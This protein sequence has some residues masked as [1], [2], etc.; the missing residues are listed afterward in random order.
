[1]RGRLRS[2]VPGPSMIVALAA[3]AIALS[4]TAYAATLIGTNQ[5]R[6]RAVTP[7]KLQNGAVS[8]PKLANA[9]VTG[10]KI[11]N[12]AV[13]SAKVKDGTLLARDFRPGELTS[14]QV[15]GAQGPQGPQGPAGP[16]GASGPGSAATLTV[17]AESLALGDVPTRHA[18][19]TVGDARFDA[20]CYLPAAGGPRVGL[21]VTATGPEI[22][23]AATRLSGPGT[24]APGN[25]LPLEEHGTTIEGSGH[26]AVFSQSGP[27]VSGTYG[28]HVWT[29]PPA[30]CT[31]TMQ[32]AG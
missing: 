5:I 13:T 1:M 22:A 15:Q 29:G 2:L 4:G 18:V 25:S 9:A 6:D 11:R 8:S 31:I 3:L 10:E 27:T 7:A 12:A 16:Q 32:V 19:L 26:V 24:L 30:R 17:A 20:V 23:V 14:G 21:Y 28:T